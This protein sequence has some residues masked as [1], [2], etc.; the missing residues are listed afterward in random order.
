[1]TAIRV[2]SIF[3]AV[4][5]FFPMALAAFLFLVETN[6]ILGS[7]ACVPVF[8]SMSRSISSSILHSEV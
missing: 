4:F 8:C 2:C 5:F 7:L 6:F 3:A 1:M